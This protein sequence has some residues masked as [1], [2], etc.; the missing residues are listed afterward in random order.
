MISNRIVDTI[1]KI[2]LLAGLYYLCGQAGLLLAAPPGNATVFWPASGLAVAFCYLCGLR[3]APGVFIGAWLMYVTPMILGEQSG[4]LADWVTL[5]VYMSLGATMQA[6]LASYLMRRFIGRRSQLESF[7]DILKFSTLAGPIACLV[8]CSMATFALYQTGVIGW[9]DIAFTWG[10]W[11]VGDALGVLVFTPSLI[12]LFSHDYANAKRKFTV[13]VPLFLLFAMIMVLFFTVKA[14]DQKVK[15]ENLDELINIINTELEGTVD[16]YIDELVELQ[17]FFD[18]SEHVEEHEFQLFVNHILAEHGDVRALLWA[19][20][21]TPENMDSILAE[22]QKFYPPYQFTEM[23]VQGKFSPIQKREVYFPVLYLRH[24]Y[25]LKNALGFDLL[26]EEKRGQAV[27]KAIDEGKPM[28]SRAISL[29]TKPNHAGNAFLIVNPVYDRNMPLNTVEQ[30]RAAAKGVVA[31][32][33]EY[34]SVVDPVMKKWAEKGIYVRLEERTAEGEEIEI[35]NTMTK[36]VHKKSPVFF[37]EHL[38]LFA[39]QIWDLDYFLTQAYDLTHI[40]WSIWYALAGSLIFMFFASAFLLAITGQ[41]AVIEKIVEEKTHEISDRNA[42]L[43]LI[44]DHVP[45]MIFVKNRKLEIVNMNDAMLET[46]GPEVRKTIIGSTG[47]EHFPEEDAKGYIEQDEK[48]FAEGYTETLEPFVD[49][50]GK[51]R[52]LFTRKIGFENNMGEEFILGLARDVTKEKEAEAELKRSN[53]ELEDFAYVAS[54]DLKAPLRHISM[55]AGFIKERY[56]PMMDEKGLELL[57]VLGKSCNRMQQMIESLLS[58]S[59]VG[60]TKK[61]FAPVDL[62]EILDNAKKALEVPIRENLA[63]VEAENTLPT[64]KGDLNLLAQL[65]QNLIQNAIKYAKPHTAP[66]IRIGAEKEGSQWKIWVADNGIG[67]E[68]E[69]AEK[70]FQIFQRLHLDHEY[71]GV[72]IGLAI[73]Q[74]IVEFHGGSIWLDGDYKNGAKFVFTLEGI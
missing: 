71:D 30:R 32:V 67:V 16:D 9:D 20:K 35:L 72:G 63:V 49:Y 44:M 48:A 66:H 42:F 41:T 13:F 53:K 14:W 59:R 12:L 6:L 29:M 57:D 21:V 31:G 68:P 28:A 69:Y 19:P 74:R 65:L 1:V 8:S 58:Y 56:K 37:S 7:G 3:M 18:S 52:L 45:D 62:N 22:A 4:S 51:I 24:H 5:P 43:K 33:F 46:L 27:Q 10:T 34:H 17:A 47:L 26:S 25:N 70:I 73:C 39:G 11:Y 54:H 38:V 36:D 15:N 23:A 64:V 61:T 50:T 60:R 55:S 2:F 40:N